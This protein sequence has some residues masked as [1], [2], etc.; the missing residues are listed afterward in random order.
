MEDV[1]EDAAVLVR[2]GDEVALADA[3]AMLVAGGPDVDWLRSR[4]PVVA[5]AHTW[6]RSAERHVEAY[7]LAARP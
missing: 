4:G 6:A 1:V 5:A 3:L 2:P 7:R